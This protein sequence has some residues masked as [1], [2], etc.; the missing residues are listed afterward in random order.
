[1]T[2]PPRFARLVLIT[3]DG[4]L[5]GAL[6]ALPVATPWWQDVAPVIEAVRAAHGI[7][8][9]VLRALEIAPNPKSV[10]VTYLAEVAA[11]VAA[12][13]PWDGDLDEQ[14]LRNSYAKLGGPTG[15]LAW[16]NEILA[17]KGL[18]P[19]GPPRQVRT[20]N[21]SSLWA[22]PVQGQTVWLK[23][24]PR[25]FA[26]EAPLIAALA[27][28]AVPTLLGQDGGRFLMAELPGQDLY[29]AEI[30]QLFAMVDL[31]VGLQAKWVGREAELFALGLPDWR[32]P[33]L[34]AAITEV[35]ERTAPELS[36]KNR[37]ALTAFIADL[38]RRFADLAAC[39][40]PDTLV[41]GDFH[42]GN[43]RGDSERLALMDWGDSG[44]G[45]PL[46]DS[47]AFLDRVPAEALDAVRAVWLAHWREA[48]PGSD[49]AKAL[50]LLAP[51]AAA[52]QAVIYRGFLD[53]IE[54]AE[55]PYHAAD[56]VDWLTRT[57]ALVRA[58]SRPG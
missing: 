41:H 57:A 53:T 38:P 14:P 56:P 5:V 8:V 30:D 22:I 33:A 37:G 58:E 10:K 12:A 54:P 15:D 47:S 9:T 11:P 46:L 16:A 34:T 43:L 24:I 21:L 27:G 55:H 48:V 51:I 44:V 50:T 42:P 35:F 18:T 40:L 29:D 23:A 45:H 28:E 6:P 31:L 1:M 26:H 32:A 3:P 20:W 4:A 52:R 7:E 49:P 25:F 17:E 13:E 39:G 19:A 36:T 2:P